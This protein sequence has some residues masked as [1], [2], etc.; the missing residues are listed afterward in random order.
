VGWLV[1]LPTN[2]SNRSSP[3]DE[4]D[5][6]T[7]SKCGSPKVET[8]NVEMAFAHGKAAPVYACLSNSVCLDC[9]LAECF[10]PQESL[11]KL[12]KLVQA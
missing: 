5:N 6:K 10:L 3:L 4:R 7:C 1:C 11:A 2:G 9:G 8:I 12:R